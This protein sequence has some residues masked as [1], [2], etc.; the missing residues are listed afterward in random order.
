MENKKVTITN[1]N[2]SGLNKLM[3]PIVKPK[4]DSNL[5]E[6]LKEIEDIQNE[7]KEQADT[8]E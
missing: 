7:E 8:V 4:K 2:K 6:I 3:N 5:E 1:E